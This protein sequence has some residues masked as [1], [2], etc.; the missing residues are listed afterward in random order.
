MITIIEN[1]I[2]KNNKVK[3]E[4]ELIKVIDGKQYRFPKNKKREY[5]EQVLVD[6]NVYTFKIYQQTELISGVMFYKTVC[7]AVFKESE[8][9][10]ERKKE[11]VNFKYSTFIKIKYPDINWKD[12]QMLIKHRIKYNPYVFNIVNMEFIDSVRIGNEDVNYLIWQDLKNNI[13]VKFC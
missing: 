1:K 10:Y 13:Y 2:T 8:E 11:N 7:E 12:A 3:I 9:E 5:K 4:N 6:E